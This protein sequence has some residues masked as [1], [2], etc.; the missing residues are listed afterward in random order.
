[1][2]DNNTGNFGSIKPD[3]FK[4]LQ[5]ELILFTKGISEAGKAMKEALS[6]ASSEELTVN[7]T[8]ALNATKSLATVTKEDLKSS[9]G[10]NDIAKKYNEIKK[11]QNIVEANILILKKKIELSDKESIDRLGKALIHAVNLADN[12][13]IAAGHAE[14][15]ATQ[16]EKVEEAGRVFSKM[17]ETLSKFPLI[18]SALAKPL[19]AAAQAAREATAEG[20]T[21][22]QAK[23]EGWLA[24]SK[25]IALT[26]GAGILSA[27][28]KASGRLGEINKQLGVGIE[29]ARSIAKEY[30]QYATNA[31]DVA[32]T[33]D[34][35]IKANGELNAALGT[36]VK[37]SGE[38]LDTFIRLTEYM[39]LSAGAA[40][41]LE[42]LS[43]TTG[44]N[45]QEFAGNLAKSVFQ[46]GKAN[47]IYIS[48]SSALEK[49]KDLS[50]TTLLNLRRN[51]E[52][53]GQA[54]VATEKLGISFQQLRNTANSLLDFESSI[55]NEL[56]AELLTG[57]Q[58]NLERARAA[59][60]KGDD[61]ALTRELSKQ[62]GSLNEF[63]KMNVIQRESLAK[64]FGMSADSMADMLLKQELMNSLGEEANNLTAEQAKKIKEMVNSGDAVN[65]S[66]ALLKLQ[67]QQDVAKNFALTVEKLK[68]AFVDFFTGFE[69]VFTGLVDT[70][71]G[72]AESK[73]LKL[74]AGGLTST[75]GLAALIGT[76]VAGKVMG[77]NPLLP[78]WVRVANMGGAA[79]GSTGGFGSSLY[80]KG[81]PG[82]TG[83][84]TKSGKPDMR[85]NANKV[86]PAT[87]GGL[88][89]LGTGLAGG[90]LGMGAMMIGDGL[91]SAGHETAGGVVSG[92]GQGAMMGA[93][94]GP[95]GMGI[96][97]AL[98][99]LVGFLNRKDKE[100][101]AEKKEEQDHFTKMTEQLRVIAKKDTEI[102]MEGSRVGQALVQSNPQLGN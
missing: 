73:L 101:K 69:P 41:K 71:K 38:T 86:G 70:I 97:A 66:D 5:D 19:Q 95:V 26:I 76:M 34:R 60:L 17:S 79:G 82:P 90:A 98:G 88:T 9:Q 33:T 15:L 59:A 78:M 54:L 21:P 13:A 52:A 32:I 84:L 31:G 67:Q 56:E 85:F 89:R 55:S 25:T 30:E 74:L 4:S 87:K 61:L 6:G 96:G 51:P 3:E 28:V 36:S 20:L 46:A 44:K 99:G 72:L 10:R 49:V 68:S 16:V 8:K 29:G 27:L 47:G 58:L 2:A 39:G 100:E 43:R 63:E 7:L 1:M 77:T 57:K 94:F 91:S 83:P 40:A 12:L 42:T 18:G 24:L 48:T 92:M 11:Q 22:G 50:G 14:K 80:R 45:T 65:E 37:F 81:S 64:A 75:V 23:L 35:L 53:I 102:Y 62:V 93:M